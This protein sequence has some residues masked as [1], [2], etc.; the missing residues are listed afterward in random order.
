MLSNEIYAIPLDTELVFINPRQSNRGRNEKTL[1][2]VSNDRIAYGKRVDN[3]RYDRTGWSG[4]HAS[5]ANFKETTERTFGILVESVSSQGSP[6]YAVVSP[7]EFVAKRE[8]Y[9]AYWEVENKRRQAVAEERQRQR[10]V[11]EEKRQRRY[12]V[13]EQ[14]RAQLAPIASRTAEVV[15]NNIIEV[16]GTKVADLA[17]VNIKAVGEWRDLD[18]DA[19]RFDGTIDGTVTLPYKAFER[20]LEKLAG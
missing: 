17:S 16:L 2:D 15:R 18:T 6:L 19:E 7:K 20:L 13:Q 12:A 11:E 1:Q 10:A 4:W 8:E 5:T 14:S 3:K 9:D